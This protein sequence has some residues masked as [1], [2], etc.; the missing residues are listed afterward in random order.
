MKRLFVLD[1]TGYL[2]RA[3][4]AIRG[5]TNPSGA[6]T[7]ALYGFI[8]SVLKLI[9][10]FEPTHICAVFDAPDNKLSRTAIYEDYKANRGAI[11]EDLPYQ[12]EAAKKFCE[13]QG[14]P[15]LM[16]PGVESDDTMGTLAKWAEEQKANVF[17]CTSDKDLMQMVDDQ[18]H[19]LQTHKDNLIIDPAKV[20]EIYGIKPTQVVDYLAIVGDSSDNVP[21]LPGFG[22]K[23]AANLLQKMGTLEEVLKHPEEVP[24]KKKQ[25]TIRDHGDLAR[26]SRQLVQLDT[27]VEIP[28]DDAFFSLQ[29]PKVE[30]LREFYQA[31]SFRTLIAELDSPAPESPRAVLEEEYRLVNSE[32]DLLAMTQELSKASEVCFDTETTSLRPLEAEIVGLGFAI[33]EGKGWYVPFNGDLDQDSIWKALTPLFENPTIGFFGHNVKYDLHVLA[34]AGVTVANVCFDTLLASYLLSAESRRHSLDALAQEHFDKIK[35]PIEELIGKGK[36][37]ISMC[38]VPLEQVSDYCCEDVDYTLRLRKVLGESL[39]ERGLL[40]LH[41]ELELPLCLVLMK[42]ERRGIFVDTGMLEEFSRELQGQISEL[43]KGIHE[44]AGE[45]FNI[46][47]PKQLSHILFEKMGIKPPKKTATGYSTN[48]EVLT[49]LQQEYPIAH[50]VLEY[51][52]LEKLRSTYADALPLE[53]NPQTGRIHCSFS[54]AVAATGRL[55]SQNPNLQNIPVRTE[56]GRRIREAFRPELP[57]WLYLSADYSQIELRLLA[58]MSQDPHMLEAFHNG[59]DIH[60][61]TAAKVFN[62]PLNEVTKE[63]RYHAKAVN[64]GIIYGQQ[65]YGLSQELGITMPEAAAFIKTYFERYPHIRDFLEECKEQAR[66]TGKAVTITGRER[67]INDIDSKNPNLR[68]AA[69]RL[70]CNTPL[71]GTAADII[72]MAMLK[73]DERMGNEKLQGDMILQIHDELIFELPESDLE[74]MSQLVKESMETVMSLRVPLTVDISV[75]KN[76]KEC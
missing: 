52:G 58:H 71:Q 70:A 29:P 43:A 12:I 55:A 65:A 60:A 14:I 36:K 51:R 40:K 73:V 56:N 67:Q 44:L 19:I 41:D 50:K 37:Q 22:P 27:D 53:V 59:E 49:K 63:Q 31:Q 64:F 46:N 16:I 7:N 33:E 47:S 57:D 32:A 42:M 11:P 62:T 34:N 24:G 23:T 54:Q 35:T 74:Q 18:V 61:S 13:M 20:E 21:G 5:M 68:N 39:K 9:K 4:Y 48:A 72:K 17:L 26:L 30:K 45:D 75:G 38:D 66:N 15:M 8:R 28:K 10:D 3:Y 25:E 6:S 2:F 76:W 69:E 1:A